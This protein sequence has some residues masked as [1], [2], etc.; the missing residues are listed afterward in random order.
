M[1]GICEEWAFE[2][3]S[4]ALMFSRVPSFIKIGVDV[5][6]FVGLIHREHGDRTSIL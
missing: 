1:R 3:A 6:K 4:G 5:A 2:I